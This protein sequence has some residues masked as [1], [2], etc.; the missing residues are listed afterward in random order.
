MWQ[1][2]LTQSTEAAKLAFLMLG[3]ILSK[4]IGLLIIV[5]VGWL[6]S[7][8]IKALVV[9]ILNSAKLDSVAES[10]GVNDV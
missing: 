6:I 9:K 7:K 4:L 5:A 8:A 10:T 1:A 2:F 3:D